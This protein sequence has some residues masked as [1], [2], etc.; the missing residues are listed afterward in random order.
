MD[1]QP[2]PKC[3]SQDTA[4][5]EMGPAIVAVIYLNCHPCGHIW[6]IDALTKALVHHVTPIRAP[7]SG[8][9]ST[10]ESNTP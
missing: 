2:C 5:M 10:P 3:G 8:G 4:T 1:K 9:R 7:R 6:T